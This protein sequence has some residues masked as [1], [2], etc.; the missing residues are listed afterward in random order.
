VASLL[1]GVR[2]E[3][4]ELLAL[5]ADAREQIAVRRVGIAG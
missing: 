5:L 1:E 2:D 3:L 4:A